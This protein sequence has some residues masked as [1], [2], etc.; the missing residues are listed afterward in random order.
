MP[1]GAVLSRASTGTYFDSAGVLKSAAVDAARFDYTWDGLL[2]VLAGLLIEVQATNYQNNSEA[3][4]GGLN[5]TDSPNVSSPEAPDGNL[6]AD[7]A[8]PT[9]TL[10]T[11]RWDSNYGSILAAGK[12]YCHCGFI[13]A[14]EEN[15]IVLQ[16]F[17]SPSGLNASASFN[18]ATKSIQ[19]SSSAGAFI[20]DLGNGW[21]RC[22]IIDES[23]VAG[24]LFSRDFIRNAGN[25]SGNDIDGLFHWGWESK[26]EDFASSYIKTSGSDAT[27]AADVLNLGLPDGSYSIEVVTPNAT[28][29]DPVTVA[30][31][32]GYDFDWADFTGATAAGERHVQTITATPQ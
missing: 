10:G 25:Y 24:I 22:G 31:G 19:S 17:S 15:S 23:P 29:T 27:R 5:L 20:Q 2:W 18:A 28:Y 8:I 30:G 1:A 13:H 11:H 16:H 3:R 4:G 7:K 14:A 32:A 9:T 6:T 21:V 12:K 26:Q